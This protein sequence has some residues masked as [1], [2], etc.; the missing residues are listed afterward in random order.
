[1]S[2][3]LHLRSD[4]LREFYEQA[5]LG[6][7]MSH[8]LTPEIQMAALEDADLRRKSAYWATSPRAFSVRMVWRRQRE[9]RFKTDPAKRSCAW[10]RE[11]IAMTL[12]GA[13]RRFCSA[14]CN[15]KL[16]TNIDSARREL[17]RSYK[18]PCPTCGGR[19]VAVTTKRIYCSTKCRDSAPHMLLKRREYMRRR[20]AA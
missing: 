7:D 5:A 10:C 4:I 14:Q 12:R 16:K 6:R 8:R 11:P 9:H 13:L 18:P 2:A 3:W 20:R 1:M 17:A 19:V 15:Q